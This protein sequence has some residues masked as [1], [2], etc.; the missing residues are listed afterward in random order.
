MNFLTL[1]YVSIVNKS[2]KQIL[3]EFLGKK[4]KNREIMFKRT[5]ISLIYGEG[6]GREEI[7]GKS[8]P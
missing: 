2:G 1:R 3:M 8:T 6:T 7:K 4:N 5:R